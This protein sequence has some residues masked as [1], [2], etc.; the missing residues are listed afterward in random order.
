MRKSHGSPGCRVATLSALDEYNIGSRRLRG[1]ARPL[2]ARR[3]FRRGDARGS[4]GWAPRMTGIFAA[5]L[6]ALLILPGTAHCM[7]HRNSEWVAAAER[8]DRQQQRQSKRLCTAL[9]CETT[10]HSASGA[11]IVDNLAMNGDHNGENG[12]SGLN[13][14]G[15]HGTKKIRFFRTDARG[16][17]S[18]GA[19]VPWNQRLSR[20]QC[21][22][23]FDRANVE[24]FSNIA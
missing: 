6:F 10:S 7:G 3:R 5:A 4:C 17:C 12:C 16:G 23:R 22:S 18:I 1:A 15:L 20:S 13:S 19:G 8:N 11:E 9:C 24:S 21:N 14:G 2:P